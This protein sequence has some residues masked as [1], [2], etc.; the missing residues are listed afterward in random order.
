MFDEND[1]KLYKA[2]INDIDDY[3]E[4]LKELKNTNPDLARQKAKDSLI[5]S[6]ILDSNGKPKERI[7]D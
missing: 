7:C 4:N 6:G 2:Y 3:I 5:R 1:T